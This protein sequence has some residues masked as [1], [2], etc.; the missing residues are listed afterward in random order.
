MQL[1]QYNGNP[2]VAHH[3]QTR[4]AR[5]CAPAR[6][7]CPTAAPAAPRV[8]GGPSPCMSHAPPQEP[9]AGHRAA[10]VTRAAQPAAPAL[11]APSR[12][13]RVSERKRE[14]GRIRGRFPPKM[15]S[16]FP[17][18]LVSSCIALFLTC[19]V[20][21]Y[22]SNLFALVSCVYFM[23]FACFEEVCQPP[24]LVH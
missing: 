12:A 13:R 5:V 24:A 22:S 2:A 17:Q 1:C 18:H 3:T 23:Y 6:A 10:P 7:A 9:A 4:V 14:T 21:R 8:G 11:T 16:V 15:G 20:M 19:I